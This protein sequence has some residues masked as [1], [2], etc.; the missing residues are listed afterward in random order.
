MNKLKNIYSFGTSFSNAGGLEFEKKPHIK[1][2]Y[3]C[4]NIP[5]EQEKIQYTN[6]LSELLDNKVNCV[7]LSKS[8]FGN[9]RIYRK[10]HDITNLNNFVPEEN[11]FIIE[12]SDLGRKEVYVNKDKKHGIINYLV[13]GEEEIKFVG[14]SY[15]YTNGVT[16]DGLSEL[17]K[18]FIPFFR[19]TFNFKQELD[20]TFANIAKTM[21]YLE[22]LKIPF[23][24]LNLP[25]GLVD[26]HGAKHFNNLANKKL[27]KRGGETIF[28]YLWQ[29]KYD[30]QSETN[31]KWEDL[32][33][34][35]RAQII[36]SKL[37]FN[38]MITSGLISNEEIPWGQI[39]KEV[40]SIKEI[41]DKN[42][43]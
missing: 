17:E 41:L 40:N 14:S 10:I 8:G 18:T 20:K 13:E 3:S 2:Y 32:H 1:D 37:I 36:L 7:N 5:L 28:S 33:F 27:V 6:L 15:D 25:F 22:Y 38:K 23:I 9:E 39:L 43:P 29:N 24:L 26:G 21:A 34:G 12:F 16:S 31:G 30:I 42:N 35:Y 19:K 11:L 4:L